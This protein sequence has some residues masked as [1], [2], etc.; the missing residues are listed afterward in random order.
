[1]NLIDRIIKKKA[2]IRKTPCAERAYGD[3]GIEPHAMY[4]CHTS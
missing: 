2:M 4:P 3:Y 1:M